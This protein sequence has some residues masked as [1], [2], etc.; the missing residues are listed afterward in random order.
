MR[1]RIQH[2]MTLE[3]F[4]RAA[5]GT[6]MRPRTLRALRDVVAGVTWAAAAQRHGITEG[7]ISR[8]WRRLK[9]A[10]Q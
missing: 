6:K 8:A 4:D 2:T 9:E 1:Q 7:G 5:A 10:S 3:Q